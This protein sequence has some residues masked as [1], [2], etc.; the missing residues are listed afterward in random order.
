MN[1]YDRLLDLMSGLKAARI[2]FTVGSVREEAIMLH[3]AVPGNVGKSNSYAP[4]KWK[5]KNSKAT[6]PSTTKPPSATSSSALK[7]NL[8][9]LFF[10]SRLPK[11]HGRAM[12]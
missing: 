11:C 2:H 9:T 8:A 3:V 1:Q 10:V 6:E 5:S 4:A 12:F 7:T